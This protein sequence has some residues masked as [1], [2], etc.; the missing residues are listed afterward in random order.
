MQA[1]S[2][3]TSECDYDFS[4]YTYTE[5]SASLRYIHLESHESLLLQQIKT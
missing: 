1:L 4:V 5:N 2:D 3:G